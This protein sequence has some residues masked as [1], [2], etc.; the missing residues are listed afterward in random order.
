MTESKAFASL[1][2]ALL[3]R[4]GHARPAMRPQGSSGFLP[5]AAISP[6]DDLGWNDMGN[7][8]GRP[9]HQIADVVPISPELALAPGTDRP[10]PSPVRQQAEIIRALA[11]PH[12]PT[13][14][15]PSSPARPGERKQRP[16]AGAKGRAAFTLRLDSD[17]HLK[18]RLACAVQNRSAQ[19]I[20]A[21]ALDL[22]LESQP[23]I[24]ALAATAR[25]Q[26]LRTNR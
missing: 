1:S 4:K 15:G 21:D 10:A 13:V 11:M 23:E 25:T 18:L 26:K 19:T 24:T 2:S 9:P 16:V 14:S 22:F 12:R 8:S 6:H 17:R 20:V 3:A 5:R 7:G